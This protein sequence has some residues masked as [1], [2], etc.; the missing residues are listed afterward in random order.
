M[1][2]CASQDV[3]HS[4]KFG[5]GKHTSQSQKISGWGPHPETAFWAPMK[6]LII[7]IRIVP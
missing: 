6:A 2:N 5:M 7:D 1:R 4:P 3:I